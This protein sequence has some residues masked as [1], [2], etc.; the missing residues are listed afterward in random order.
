MA[1]I[2][3]STRLQQHQVGKLT[4]CFFLCISLHVGAYG[5]G[6]FLSVDSMQHAADSVTL[7]STF[8]RL[9]RISSERDVILAVI[10]KDSIRKVNYSQLGDL[11]FR[12]TSLPALSQG[13]LGQWDGVEILGSLPDQQVFSHNAVPMFSLT[14]GSYHPLTYSPS[15][16]ER[17]E[18][19]AGTDAIGG[20]PAL[21]V[22]GVNIQKI[23]YNTARPFTSMWYHQ[24]AGDLV[25]GNVAFAQNISPSSSVAA[26]IRR[27]GARGV[28]R[29]TDFDAWNVHLQGRVVTSGAAGLLF[30]Y[31]VS[32][33][34]VDPWGGV[35]SD[36]YGSADLLE[37]LSPRLSIGRESARRHDLSAAYEIRDIAD[38]AVTL[39]ATAYASSD[40]LR[41]VDS[42]WSGWYAGAMSTIDA[43]IGDVRLLGGFRIQL[44]D[45]GS[46]LYRSEFAGGTTAHTWAKATYDVTSRLSLISSARYDGGASGGLGYGV[47]LQYRDSSSAAKLDA[48]WIDRN[49]TAAP[50]ALYYAHASWHIGPAMITLLAYHHNSMPGARSNSGGSATAQSMV[51][52]FL[53][54][55]SV[56]AVG[57]TDST[58][59]KSMLYTSALLA[60]VY[61][62]STSSIH[63]GVDYSLVGAG[64]LPQFNVYQRSFT[65]ADLLQSD[66]QSNG[67]S[68]FAR[69]LVGTASIRASLDN[70]IGTR[71]YTVAFMP[72]LPRQFRLSVDWTFVD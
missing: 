36:P 11:L 3:N 44:T 34:D 59:R 52:S 12:A 43:A 22:A 42:L 62:T 70:V 21:S 55:G 67:L 47:S 24:G 28:L 53:V 10:E 33:I 2:I 57:R 71:W 58:I 48:S 5:R 66:S 56:M 60:Y 8:T 9:G 29:N 20:L 32:T 27:T 54:R 63:L 50:E 25:A 15:A 37:S 49:S 69:V 14:G 13:S 1:M 65:A 39:T 30:T 41:R 16:I 72:E 64:A 38:S 61:S 31:D 18:V 26:N 17:V 4:W 51:G 40:H 68:L 7:Q 6:T 35:S 23:S 45:A 19:L 46:M